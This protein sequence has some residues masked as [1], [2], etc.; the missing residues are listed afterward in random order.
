MGTQRRGH[1]VGH[2][3]GQGRARVEIKAIGPS[4]DGAVDEGLGAVR[5]IVVGSMIRGIRGMPGA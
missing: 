2:D 1:L 3:L 5:V 4:A